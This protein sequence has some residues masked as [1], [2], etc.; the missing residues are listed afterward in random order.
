[1]KVTRQGLGRGVGSGCGFEGDRVAEGFEL[2][3]LVAPPGVGVDV[4]VVVESG[5]SSWG[6]ERHSIVGA[7]C[8][9]LTSAIRT[10]GT[11]APRRRSPSN[12]HPLLYSS[13]STCPTNISTPAAMSSSPRRAAPANQL[14]E[15]VSAH[16]VLFS[17]RP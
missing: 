1:M 3:D 13:R 9:I 14:P 11:D 6:S 8:A 15:I 4:S 5:P 12:A 2:A 16:S 17:S 10:D 7:A